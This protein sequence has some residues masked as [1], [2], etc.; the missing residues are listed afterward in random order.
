MAKIGMMSFAHMHANSYA[1]CLNTLPDV[2]FVGI[3]DDDTERGVENAETYKTTF[4]ESVD[5]FLAQDMNG[6]IVCSENVKHR[7]MVEQAAAAGKWILCEKPLAPNRED[8]LAM[9]DVCKK[10]D[11]GLGTAFPCRYAPSIIAVK[12]ELD[13]GVYGEIY[14]ASCTNNGSYPGGWFGDP[15]LSGGGAT[16]DHTV[17]VADLMRWMLGKEFKSVYCENGSL[18]KEACKIDDV[19][20]MHME[21]DG[22]TNVSHIASWNRAE[23][24]PT[25]G[26]VT[27]ELI[28][29][30]GVVFIDAFNQKI[31]VYN[32]NTMRAAW[33]YWGGDM[34]MGLVKD[35]AEACD[36]K[37]DPAI[38]G[39]DG[40]KAVEV[41]VAAEQSAKGH[42]TVKV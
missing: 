33:E 26:D 27:I 22:G 29:E 16:M 24:Y 42:K 1:A 25:W 38:T 8:C 31:D 6:V 11:V 35:F 7:Q 15:E 3:W 36:E 2:E 34:D 12:Q 13:D 41:T 23:S 19:A 17:H 14:A 18:I 32:D 5:D 9:I 28:G 21:M 40:L 10:A 37:R 39:E 4:F 30:K 20:S